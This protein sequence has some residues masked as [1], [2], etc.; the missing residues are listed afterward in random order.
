M[1]T[2]VGNSELL[3]KAVAFISEELAENP[4]KNRHDLVD[5]AAMRFNLS[6]K[7]AESLLRILEDEKHP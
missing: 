7:E 3:T 4:K 6:P 5:E 2:V 1:A